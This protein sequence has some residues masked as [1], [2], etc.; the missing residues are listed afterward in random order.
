MLRLER[1][2][3]S[4]QNLR[5]EVHLDDGASVEAV[6]YRSHSLCVS[7]QVGCAVGCPFC[8]SGAFGLTRPL[9]LEEMIGQVEAVLADGAEVT[10]VTVSG[11]GEPLHNRALLPF[12]DW[13]RARRIAPSLTTSGGPL[14]RLVEAL[15]APHNGLTVSVHAGT[16]PTRAC[17]VP[18][19]PGLDALFEVLGREVPGLSRKRRKK[20]AL[21]YLLVDGLNDTDAEV[22]AFVARSLPLGLRAHLYAYN[23]VPTSTLG[24]VG[25][26]RY[27][28]VYERMRAAGLRVHMSSQARVE[29]NGGCGTLVAL[30]RAEDGARVDSAG[31]G[32]LRSAN[33]APRL[34]ESP[35]NTT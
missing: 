16:E 29:A 22:D 8:A 10:R 15:H 30:R 27:E 7:C 35:C 32:V 33:G 1:V 3:R 13:C 9:S 11:V 2:Q 4:P 21:A 5:Y 12:L 20:T 31:S 18:H 19:A 6:L 24:P 34:P 17:A 28:A 26:D 14:D 23:A 25:R